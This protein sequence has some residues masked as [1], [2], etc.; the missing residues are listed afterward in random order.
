MPASCRYSTG[1]LR[2]T[3]HARKLMDVLG[4][5]WCTS[6][7]VCALSCPVSM[8]GGTGVRLPIGSEAKHPVDDRAWQGAAAQD[9]GRSN[10]YG[11]L[12]VKR[13]S[14][15]LRLDRRPGRAASP[16]WDE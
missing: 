16:R 4:S 2:T 7:R 11:A 14:S 12:R 1:Q 3:F 15:P 6:E 13:S 5:F 8:V 9:D 10:L